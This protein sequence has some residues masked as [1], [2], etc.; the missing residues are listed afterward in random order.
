M[1][2]ASGVAWQSRGTFFQSSGDGRGRH[3]SGRPPL[4]TIGGVRVAIRGRFMT[5]ITSEVT[6]SGKSAGR[7]AAISLARVLGISAKSAPS[8][9]VS[10][11]G[12]PGNSVDDNALRSQVH[13]VSEALL[14]ALKIGGR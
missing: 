6:V 7:L 13:D 1:A 3:G 8:A 14:D 10:Q 5:S 9:G 12:P 2:S 4:L 11:Q